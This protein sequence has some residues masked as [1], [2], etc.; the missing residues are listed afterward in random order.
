MTDA[1]NTIE[2]ALG[3]YEPKPKPT[4]EIRRRAHRRRQTR[5][6]LSGFVALVVSVLAGGL[7]WSAFGGSGREPT[8]PAGPSVSGELRAIVNGIGVDRPAGW[9]LIEL[10]GDIRVA[11][12]TRRSAY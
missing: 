6:V 11:G 1:R 9:T 10:G 2:R 5:R 4:E 12:D 8:G 7:L 3:G